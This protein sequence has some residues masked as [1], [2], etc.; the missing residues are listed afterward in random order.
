MSQAVATLGLGHRSKQGKLRKIE[1]NKKKR[2]TK[3]KGKLRKTQTNNEN[4]GQYK[5]KKTRISLFYKQKEGET[6]RQ[7]EDALGIEQSSKFKFVSPLSKLAVI[8]NFAKY[9]LLQLF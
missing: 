7:G 2:K 9:N 5:K 1:T 6:R 8:L 3:K 4:K